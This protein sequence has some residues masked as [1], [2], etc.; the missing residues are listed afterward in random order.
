VP[1]WTAFSVAR[2]LEEHLPELVDY[3]FTAQM[4]D[5]L[6]AIS[7]REEE[8]V[9]YL[10]DFYFG[11]GHPG[12]KKQLESKLNEIDARDLARF[13]LGRPESGE[14]RDEVVV[15][16]GKYG[17]F[18]EQGERKAS[19]PEDLPPDELN[20]AKAVEMLEQ[21]SLGQ[22]PLGICPDTQRPVYLKQGRFG[23][24]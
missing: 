10:R 24:G 21:A 2:L 19:I 7:R 4:E 1:T 18:I 17:P 12:L 14:H 22:E 23:P 13:S 11:N 15:R 9:K 8:P 5:L 20:L 3:Q 16:V 6:D